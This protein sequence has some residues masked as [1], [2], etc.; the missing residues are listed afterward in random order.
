VL[1]DAV[2]NVPAGSGIGG[3]EECSVL[4]GSGHGSEAVAAAPPYPH[5]IAHCLRCCERE[6]AW[7]LPLAEPVAIAFLQPQAHR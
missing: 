7:P 4:L 5:I 1:G 2:Q 3:S 6:E